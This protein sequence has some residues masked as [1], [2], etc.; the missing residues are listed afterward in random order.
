[1]LSL[2]SSVNIVLA[3]IIRSL[4]HFQFVFVYDVNWSPLDIQLSQ[5]PLL[6][7]LLF[8]PLNGPGTSVKKSIVHTCVTLFLDYHL[9][10]IGIYLSLCHY[11][12]FDHF[13]FVVS[14][15]SGKW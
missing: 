9:H 14:F 15:E 2:F 6:K 11:D 5:H 4:I 3:L 8:P 7:R 12:T 10:S 1:M 13:S